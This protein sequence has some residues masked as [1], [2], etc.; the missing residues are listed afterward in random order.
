MRKYSSSIAGA[1]FLLIV[2]SI[3]SRG[4][5]FFREVVFANTF[6]LNREFEIYLVAAVLPVLINSAIYYLAQNYFIPLFN[7]HN[8]KDERIAFLRSQFWLFFLLGTILSFLLY[9]TGTVVLRFYI[10][11][12]TEAIYDIADKVYNIY[13][14]SFP[15]NA[16]YSIL[17]AY[18][19][20]ELKFKPSAVSQLFLNIPIIIFVWF[21]SDSL[22]ILSIPIGYLT[23]SFLQLIYLIFIV[24]PGLLV[25]KF[26]RGELDIKKGLSGSL[27]L[28]ILIELTNQLHPFID[29]YFLDKVEQGGIA[30]LNYA[31]V[32]F[33]LPVTIFSF[34]LASVIFP[35]LSKYINS[36]TPEKTNY[37]YLK[38]L[39]VITVF[40]I[41][42]SIIYFFNGDLIIA[43]V[44][45]RGNFDSGDTKMTFTVLRMYSISMVFYAGYALINKMIFSSGLLKQLLVLSLSLIILKILLN[46]YFAESLQQK[47]LALSSSMNFI[48]LSLCGYYLVARTVIKGE[49]MQFIKDMLFFGLL[50]LIMYLISYELINLFDLSNIPGNI[51]RIVIF[52]I[53]YS[54]G[55]LFLSFSEKSFLRY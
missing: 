32:M 36:D 43:A 34:A 37:Y 1:V 39:R 42:V 52:I 14:L 35:L 38:S 50:G 33:S 49:R 9:L 44:F 46:G 23:G 2:T 11:K 8:S 13:L 16:A 22:M 31:S 26:K 20:A 6:G 3:L 5:G 7:K 40:F 28:I 25:P 27:I 4:I 10:G 12:S 55:I 21:F 19:Q 15:L 47:G 18:L 29:R 53:L 41:P 17:V 45:Q 30:S 54:A 24:G 51:F 48:L